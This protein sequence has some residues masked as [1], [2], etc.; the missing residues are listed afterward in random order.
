MKTIIY[1]CSVDLTRSGSY[2]EHISGLIEAALDS[3]DEVQLMGVGIKNKPLNV[4][5]E[6]LKER[7]LKMRAFSF[8]NVYLINL[9]LYDFIAAIW[10]LRIN[11]L[12]YVWIRPYPFSILQFFVGYFRSFLVYKEVNGLVYHE[13]KLN[14]YRFVWLAK[15]LDLLTAKLSDYIICVT[16]KLADYYRSH[17]IDTPI[18]FVPNGM[19]K[20]VN[21][22]RR[23]TYQFGAEDLRILFFGSLA[24]WQGLSEFMK[25]LSGYTNKNRIVLHIA[26]TGKEDEKLDEYSKLFELKVY[27]HGWLNEEQLDLLMDNSHLAV[28]PRLSE[29]PLG[30]PLKLFRCLTREVPVLA[31][32]VD[33][34]RE[35][36]HLR[37]SI[38]FYEP[39]SNDTCFSILDQILNGQIDLNVMGSECNRIGKKY[40]SWTSVY[41][42]IVTFK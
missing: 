41:E 13:M 34:I 8:S 21:S 32:M 27:R 10:L 9:F 39:T 38:L 19:P 37:N 2:I 5:L 31:T 3:G 40:Y 42:K 22:V 17:G 14:K 1:S 16:P 4:G 30:S 11:K 29:G 12:S 36:E 24:P 20:L 25:I 23:V 28:I 26:G 15:K 33:G 35:L 7:G 18:L 6:I